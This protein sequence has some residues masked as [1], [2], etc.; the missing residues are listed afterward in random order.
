LGGWGDCGGVGIKGK[1]W[2]RGCGAWEKVVG[3]TR[4]LR[5]KRREKLKRSIQNV[6]ERPVIGAGDSGGG[7]T[8]AAKKKK[9]LS[10]ERRAIK[11]KDSKEGGIEGKFRGIRKRKGI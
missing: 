1:E 6:A 8:K 10:P 5:P 3:G 2:G 11:E 7:T 9:G 4:R